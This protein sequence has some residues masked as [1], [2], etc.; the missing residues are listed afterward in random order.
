MS[1]VDTVDRS[2][3]ANGFANCGIIIG[4]YRGNRGDVRGFVTV[5]G[6]ISCAGAL[7]DWYLV[8]SIGMCLD[9]PF[10]VFR[11]A[12][13]RTDKFGQS[14]KELRI[15]LEPLSVGVGGVG[16]QLNSSA[17]GGSRY[18]LKKRVPPSKG[19]APCF[20]GLFCRNL[21]MLVS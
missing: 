18:E 14:V 20:P 2:S 19:T 6:K 15:S 21:P 11:S 9:L 1:E 16:G 10:T 17:D 5:S 4:T 13:E 7:A 12:T 3:C 8:M